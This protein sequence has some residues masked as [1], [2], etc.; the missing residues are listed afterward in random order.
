MNPAVSM[1]ILEGIGAKNLAE[2]LSLPSLASE[3]PAKDK[4]SIS[5][6]ELFGNVAS[7]LEGFIVRTIEKREAVE[8][9]RTFDSVFPKYIE[10]ALGLSFLAQA[11]VPAHVLEVLSAESFSVMEAEFRD[12]A[13]E[14]FGATVR[15][16]ATFTVWTLRRISEVCR[17]IA[18]AP[19]IDGSLRDKELE[20]FK[21]FTVHSMRT[22]FHLDCL[23]IGRAHV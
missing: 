15:D 17:K 11:F 21:M 13:L 22:R 1:P 9:R 12:H 14:A 18:C 3:Q 20:L 8:F 6:Q 16:Q 2:M 10:G 19:A 5:V 7:A 23:Q 4:L